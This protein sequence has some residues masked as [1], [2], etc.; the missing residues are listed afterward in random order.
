MRFGIDRRRLV[1]PVAQPEQLAAHQSESDEQQ[2]DDDRD[3]HAW[4]SPLSYRKP[5][6]AGCPS[7]PETLPAIRELRARLD[8]LSFRDALTD[9]VAGC[10]VCAMPNPRNSSRSPGKSRPPRR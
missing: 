2:S 6:L 5:T 3:S 8:G 9:W 4:G 7:R 10:A 1:E